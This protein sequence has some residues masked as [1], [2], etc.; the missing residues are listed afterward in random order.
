MLQFYV[1]QGSSLRKRCVTQPTIMGRK[2]PGFVL[3]NQTCVS[4][5][6][7]Q[8]FYCPEFHK[9]GFFAKPNMRMQ[10]LEKGLNMQW[11]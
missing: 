2:C 4:K 9:T 1:T 6:E 10:R 7:T 11:M 8:A 3:K 5:M